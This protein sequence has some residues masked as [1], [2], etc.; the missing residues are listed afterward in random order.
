V[1]AHQEYLSVKSLGINWVDKE[2]RVMI[3]T[4]GAAGEKCVQRTYYDT[5]LLQKS[6]QITNPGSRVPI[7]I[8]EAFVVNLCQEDSEA[9]QNV[10]RGVTQFI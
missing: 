4:I 8:H 2:W 9:V 10:K 6:L 5:L 1:G 7:L 3:L